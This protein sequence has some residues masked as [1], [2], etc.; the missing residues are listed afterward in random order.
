MV[1]VWPMP[2]ATPIKAERLTLCS[3]ETM[4]L[5]A[6]TW[7]GSVACRMPR[8][9]PMATMVSRPI[10]DEFQCLPA[11]YRAGCFQIRAMGD[12]ELLQFFNALT[13]AG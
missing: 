7:S 6:I 4:V 10:I 5:T 2:Q 13:G 3:R 12:Q 1:S 11:S 9:N 8:K